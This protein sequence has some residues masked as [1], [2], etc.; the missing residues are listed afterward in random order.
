MP[1]SSIQKYI[2][3]KLSL[4][5]ETEVEISCCGQ[6]VNPIQ[7]LRNLIERWLRFGPARTLQTVVGSS[8]GDYVMVISYGRSKAA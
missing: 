5:S 4:P 2:M 1:A 8:G 7:P 3:Q 6:P